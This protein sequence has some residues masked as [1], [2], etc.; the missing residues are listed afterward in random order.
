MDVD[1]YLFC[2]GYGY[3]AGIHG[4]CRYHWQMMLF[5]VTL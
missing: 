4:L 5:F 2:S 3:T 1:A